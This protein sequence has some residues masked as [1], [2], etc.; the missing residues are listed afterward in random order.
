MQHYFS[1]FAA[2]PKILIEKNSSDQIDIRFVFKQVAKIPFL[3]WQFLRSRRLVRQLVHGF[4]FNF[5][6]AA[7]FTPSPAF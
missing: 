3:G 4:T 5:S 1:E 2:A 6:A 7:S